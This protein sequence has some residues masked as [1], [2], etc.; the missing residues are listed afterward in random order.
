ME[1]ERGD[2]AGGGG[3]SLG[4]DMRQGRADASAH[5]W[6]APAC[7]DTRTSPPVQTSEISALRHS[8]RGLAT[9]RV[10]VRCACWHYAAAVRLESHGVAH[11]KLGQFN[12]GAALNPGSQKMRFI[13]YKLHIALFALPAQNRLLILERKCV[14]KSNRRLPRMRPGSR[15]RPRQDMM[16]GQEK[17]RG[18]VGGSSR[19]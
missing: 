3:G 16:D 15:Q 6:S 7:N 17:T 18:R 1:W 10:V 2:K 11:E 8:R 4:V 9:P 19:R 14:Y 13:I 5:S 12:L